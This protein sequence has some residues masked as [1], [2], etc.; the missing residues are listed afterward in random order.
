MAL[1]EAEIAVEAVGVDAGLVRAELDQADAAFGRE[2]ERVPDHERAATL[3]RFDKGNI[4]V[5]VNVAVLTEGYD[6]QPVSCVILLRPCS[7]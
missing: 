3:T 6:S 4:Q 7:F 1:V 5:L 2:G